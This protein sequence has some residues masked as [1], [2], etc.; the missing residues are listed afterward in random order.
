MMRMR[1]ILLLLA[2]QESAVRSYPEAGGYSYPS[3][4][5]SGSGI[6]AD[7]L[8]SA[9]P[10]VVQ[11]ANNLTWVSDICQGYKE[12]AIFEVIDQLCRYFQT[13]PRLACTTRTSQRDQLYVFAQ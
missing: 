11:C 6:M 5:L 4:N 13:K 10:T 9:L 3:N 12:H 7:F 2:L 8:P 1:A